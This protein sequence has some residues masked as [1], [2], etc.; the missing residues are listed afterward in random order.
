MNNTAQQGEDIKFTLQGN[1]QINLD[2]NDFYVS[3]YLHNEGCEEPTSLVTLSKDEN[4][5]AILDSEENKTNTY[6]GRITAETTANMPT[7]IYNM[8]LLIITPNNERS[9]YKHKHM[10]TLECSVSKNISL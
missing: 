4:F 6:L 2:D 9:I 7:G 1:D 5:E 10:F 3:V 8:E